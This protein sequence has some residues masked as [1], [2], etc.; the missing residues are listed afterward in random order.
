MERMSSRATFVTKRLFPMVW[1]GF[2]ALFF[3][4]SIAGAASGR[5]I[6]F[7]FFIVPVVM[8]AFGYFLMRN[9]VFDLADEVWDAGAEL[10]VKNKGREVR[11]ALTDIVNVSYA[12]AT[13]P[14]R[15]TLTL[16]QPTPFGREIA[17]A[18]PVAWIP[19]AK[20][21][22]IEKLIERI[23]RARGFRS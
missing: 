9:L 7:E 2:V 15:V 12:V 21:P 16:R 3:L 5:Q 19:F 18:A 4:S 13:S 14:Q 22:I 17:F 8:A 1:F 20:S 11:V 23:D 10:V 6:P